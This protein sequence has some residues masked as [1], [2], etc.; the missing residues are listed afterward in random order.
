MAGGKH[1]ESEL[2][3]AGTLWLFSDLRGH[4][5]EGRTRL[6]AALDRHPDASPAPKAKAM[7]AAALL[8]WRQRDHAQAEALAAESLRMSR[9]IPDE[10]GMACS[11]LVLGLIA[12]R[13]GRFQDA[14]DR[15]AESVA[16]FRKL[17]DEWGTVWSLR[18]LGIVKF[19]QGDMTASAEHF[20]E[21]LAISMT[22]RALG[23]I[24]AALHGLGRIATS[25]H[26]FDRATALPQTKLELVSR[27]RRPDGDHGLLRSKYPVVQLLAAPE[28]DAG[29]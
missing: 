27:A 12:R 7:Y 14:A 9:A 13:E 25:Q 3:L 23:G 5:K 24:A 15:H 17:K 16:L 19:Y 11:L 1:D 4:W 8:A 6:N 20:R 2:R 29:Q 22:Q 10:F 18:L 26:S 28:T 21:S